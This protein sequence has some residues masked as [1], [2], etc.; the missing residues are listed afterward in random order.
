[1]HSVYSITCQPFL[2]AFFI[3]CHFREYNSLCDCDCKRSSNKINVMCTSS[4][5]FAVV[6]VAVCVCV[7]VCMELCVC[8]CVHAYM[9]VCVCVCVWE[10]ERG[11]KGGCVR[12]RVFILSQWQKQNVQHI[13][14]FN[15]TRV[16]VSLNTYFTFMQ[17]MFFTDLETTQNERGSDCH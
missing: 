12:M 7:F 14:D 1:M 3:Q 15:T 16:S 17:W 5:I 13:T 4:F 2:L 9:H 10:R 11:K 8:V 6:L